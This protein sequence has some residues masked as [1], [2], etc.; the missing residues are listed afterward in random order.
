MKS[1]TNWHLL[2]VVFLFACTL[3]V[4]FPEGDFLRTE[5][6]EII[7]N[8]RVGKIT[9]IRQ[10]HHVHGTSDRMKTLIGAY[11][12]QMLKELKRLKPKFIFAEGLLEDYIVDA[13]QN[14]HIVDMIKNRF[15]KRWHKRVLPSTDQMELLRK[16]GAAIIYAHLD[17]SVVLKKTRSNEY[18]QQSKYYSFKKMIYEAEKFASKMVID[19]LKKHKGKSVVLIFGAGHEFKDNFLAF[20]PVLVS[21]H[22]PEF[23]EKLK[24]HPNLWK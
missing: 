13:K 6:T 16:F 15:S 18:S 20:N 2:R 8:K 4:A 21:V 11:Q 7:G 14:A 23:F 22:F 17:T 24:I 10:I 5:K 9:Y 12:F 3:Q 1:L 19:F